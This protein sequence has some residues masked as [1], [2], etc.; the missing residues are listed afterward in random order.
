MNY[1]EHF[2]LYLPSLKNAINFEISVP[3]R[4]E[5]QLFG[6]LEAAVPRKLFTVLSLTC[7][8]AKTTQP[9][10]LNNMIICTLKFSAIACE[11]SILTKLSAKKIHQR[12]Q[13][14]YNIFFLATKDLSNLYKL[15]RSKL[16]T[17]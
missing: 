5:S 1:S 3:A 15:R 2:T 9:S 13:S 14:C 16:R 11:N 6:M 12:G 17:S 4:S 7:N 8:F 10:L